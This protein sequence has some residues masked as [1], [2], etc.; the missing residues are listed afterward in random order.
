[1]IEDNIPLV[2][3]ILAGHSSILGADHAGYKNHVYRMINFCFA[4]GD[5]EEEQRTKVMI[6][7]CFHDLGIWP[8]NTLDYLPP[9]INLANEYLAKNGLK[10]WSGEITKMIDM[11]HRL[12]KCSDDPLVELFRRGDLVDFSL[13]VFRCGISSKQVRE[14][15][16]RFPNAGFHRRLVRLAAARLFRHPLD[17]VPVLKW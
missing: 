1:M 2:D 3:E 5:L 10:G 17:P 11:H 7:G 4:Q 9:S 16:G 6:A 8:E 14:V 13:G 12:R 15:K